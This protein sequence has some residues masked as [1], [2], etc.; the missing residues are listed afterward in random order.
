MP[1]TN[2]WQVRRIVVICC[3]ESKTSSADV[4]FVGN[5]RGK[6]P[7][8]AF[9]RFLWSSM[10]SSDYTKATAYFVGSILRMVWSPLFSVSSACLNTGNGEF[11][12]VSL[13]SQ[14]ALFWAEK[15]FQWVA[16]K[17][18]QSLNY[19]TWVLLRWKN[20]HASFLVCS[21][22]VNRSDWLPPRAKLSDGRF[23]WW[24][25]LQAEWGRGDLSSCWIDRCGGQ[26]VSS[27]IAARGCQPTS[28][29]S[30]SFD[31]ARVSR[32]RST[33]KA[34]RCCIICA[35]F[36]PTDPNSSSPT[37][38]EFGFSNPFCFANYECFLS[39]TLFV[40]Y[41]IF[42]EVGHRIFHTEVAWDELGTAPERSR[43]PHFPKR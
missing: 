32:V 31:E 4:D 7:T 16:T 3:S 35:K 2:R 34:I 20:I 14:E 18:W 9:E 38:R 8:F 22:W 30:G 23:S 15:N 5:F 29:G 37:W 19:W 42:P 43:N 24:N 17:L 36:L 28:V 12:M 40:S 13:L 25:A 39:E 6:L 21:A 27:C 11:A 33:F 41:G 10:W 26:R 1:K